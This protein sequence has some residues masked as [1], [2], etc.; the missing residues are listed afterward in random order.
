MSCQSWWWFCCKCRLTMLLPERC[1]GCGAN[2]QDTPAKV[3][4][5]RP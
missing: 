3:G 1:R 4:G 5:W 2:H